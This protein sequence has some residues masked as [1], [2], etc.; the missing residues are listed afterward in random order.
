MLSLI[1]LFI[2]CTSKVQLFQAPPICSSVLKDK[3]DYLKVR[4]S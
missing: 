1:A 4:A 3:A 2:S